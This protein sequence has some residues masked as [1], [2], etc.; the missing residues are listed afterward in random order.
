MGLLQR[1]KCQSRA[2]SPP[3]RRGL[4][5]PAIKGVVVAGKAHFKGLPM[6]HSKKGVFII[7][8]WNYR[9]LRANREKLQLLIRRLQ[10]TYVWLQETI[11]GPFVPP[12]PPAGHQT[13]F[14]HMM[15]RVFNRRPIPRWFV[16]CRQAIKERRWA[17]RRFRPHVTDFYRGKYKQGKAQA[18]DDD[19]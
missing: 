17:F 3:T 7:L 14:L 6:H 9:D 8:K 1:L 15:S 2:H 5:S 12:P 13:F 19:S 16:E 11:L 18:R 4:V 10:P